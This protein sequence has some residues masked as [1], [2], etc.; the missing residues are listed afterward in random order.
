[1]W[2]TS[3]ADKQN[4]CTSQFPQNNLGSIHKH[5]V[6]SLRH[7]LVCEAMIGRPSFSELLYLPVTYTIVTICS[8]VSRQSRTHKCKR[9]RHFILNPTAQIHIFTETKIQQWYSFPSSNIIIFLMLLYTLDNYTFLCFTSFLLLIC[10]INWRCL[11]L[12]FKLPSPLWI[13]PG[14][15]VKEEVKCSFG[16]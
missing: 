8:R 14:T 12:F 10:R 5:Q 4:N 11:T 2:I 6:K 1:M 16:L 15:H 13:K 9:V 3:F 7:V